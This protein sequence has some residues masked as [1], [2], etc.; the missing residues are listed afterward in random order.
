MKKTFRRVLVILLAAA[1]LLAVLLPAMSILAHASAV[2][3]EDINQLK[4]QLSDISDRKKEVQGRLASIRDDLAQAKEAL[5]LVNEQ[6]VLTE[7]QI[8]ATQ[9]LIDATQTQIDATQGQID[10][11]Q[12]LLDQY[13]ADIARKEAEIAELEEQERQQ[14]EEYYAQVRW[15]DEH[16]S[17]SYLSILF[18]ASSF[19]ELLDS[20]TIIGDL[21]DY[22]ERIVNRLRDTQAQLAGAR[23]ELQTARDAQAQV[24]AQLEEQKAQLEEQKAQQVDQKAQLEAQKVQLERD[25]AD[26]TALMEQIAA[27][28][29]EAAAE[30]AAL[31]AAEAEVQRAL[32]NAE[33]K[34]ADQLAALSQNHNANS[35]EW[36]WPLTGK[37]GISSLFGGRYLFGRW[38][39]H[40]GTDIPAAG[41]TPIHAA[42]D[43]IVTY[44]SPN[45]N[46]SYGWYCM[47]SHG[48][49]YTTLYAHQCQRPVVSEGQSVSKGQ[50]IGY[51]GTTGNSTGNHLHFE[52]RVNGV[53][54]DVLR[55]Y[56]NVRFTGYGT[57]WYGA[58]YPSGM[59]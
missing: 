30:A 15:M 2:T 18:E 27:T 36:Y 3:Q 46:T 17:V 53:R 31:A 22:N 7:Q 51:V 32:R 24:Q 34:Y 38:E 40:T 59:R 26:A 35:G 57:S 54:S 55:L 25:K 45:R 48:S 10:A 58:N 39:S 16:G 20:I 42:K 13:D 44:V 49:G 9:D 4:D 56:P 50:V 23:D 28:E 43:G 47:I 6:V 12:A 14:L 8:S 41:G 1:L 33:Q 37:Y 29:S 52:L 21:I 5:E 11:S 19:S